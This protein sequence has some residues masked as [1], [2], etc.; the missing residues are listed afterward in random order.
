MGYVWLF[1]ETLHDTWTIVPLV[2]LIVAVILFAFSLYSSAKRGG[3]AELRKMLADT[4]RDKGKAL[5]T[6]AAVTFLL[7]L[8][9]LTPKRLYDA[10]KSQMGKMLQLEASLKD[11]THNIHTEDP[12]YWNLEKAVKA[13]SVL[14]RTR[15]DKECRV[16]MTMPAKG[17]N[18]VANIVFFAADLAGCPPTAITA[19]GSDPEKEAAAMKG[20]EADIVTIHAPKSSK[21]MIPFFDALGPLFSIHRSYETFPGMPPDWV[22]LQFGA[23]VQWNSQQ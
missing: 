19:D 9:F 2:S 17:N 6:V 14:R 4:W 23:D 7:Y 11:R 22:W 1:T 18:S 12:A 20:A 16:M 8:L 10:H 13:F 3:K 21:G 5:L 15:G